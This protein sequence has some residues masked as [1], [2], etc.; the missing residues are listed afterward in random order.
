ML[1]KL[2][3]P[4]QLNDFLT[5]KNRIIMA[6]MTRNV[7]DNN[8]VPT[9]AMAEYYARRAD[10]GLIITEGTI[11]R[12]DARGYSNVPGIYTEAQIAGWQRITQAVHKAGGKIFSQ[13][14]HVGRVSHPYFIHGE[15]PISASETIMQGEIKRIQ[16]LKYGKSR[17]ATLQEIDELIAS[18]ANAAKNAMRAGFDGIEIHG[19]NGYL[20]DQFLHHHTNLRTDQYG[21][22]S[23]NM[24]RFAVEVVKACGDAIGFEQVGIRLSPGAYLNEIIGDVRDALAFQS[25]LE[26]LNQ[27][28][29]AYVHTGSF[30]DTKTY[31]ELNHQTMTTFIRTHYHGTVIACG[32]YSPEQAELGLSENEFDLIAFGRPLIANPDFVE[33]LKIKQNLQTYDVSMLQ[34]LN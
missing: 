17:A 27:L 32:G 31:A 12:L 2:F 10:T 16:G 14:W 18:F 26:Q 11:I 23:Q 30:D 22:T 29:I 28:P 5:L 9:Q 20:I 13:I 25:L 33:R 34:Q 24:A 6:P 1:N 4:Y 7:A 15:L 19:A 8:F 3:T 21:G